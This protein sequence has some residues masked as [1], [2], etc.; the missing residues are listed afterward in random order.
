M[1]SFLFLLL[2][3]TAHAESD[4]SS[5]ADQTEQRA[6]RAIAEASEAER[7]RT[8]RAKE[9]FPRIR[10][11][12][13]V[14]RYEDG[15]IALKQTSHETVEKELKIKVPKPIN[16]QRTFLGTVELE[17]DGHKF[18][19][20]ATAKGTP[21]FT[22]NNPITL[23]VHAYDNKDQVIGN[24]QASVLSLPSD[25]PVVRMYKNFGDS[26]RTNVKCFHETPNAK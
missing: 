3:N 9:F 5:N 6:A 1:R 11:S 24:E 20:S 18:T 14:T 16:R 10:C 4:H 25:E 17:L 2:L 23:N 8:E 15:G 13:T 12:M 22:K 7:Q 26:A 21:D 19:V